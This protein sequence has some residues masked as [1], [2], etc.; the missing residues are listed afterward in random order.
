MSSFQTEVVLK[1]HKLS[2][3]AVTPVRATEGA[4]GL[5][6]YAAYETDLPPMS[7]TMVATDLAIELPPNCYGRVA[8]TSGLTVKK[9][10]DVGAGVVDCD[11]RGN[12]SVVLFNFGKETVRLSAGTK[13]AQLICEKIYTP[14]LRIVSSPRQLSETVRG[15]GGF[16]STDSTG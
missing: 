13:I 6:L 15:C 5:D 2:E 11:Y 14:E 10:I 16:G 7:R 4:A 3:F 9:F 12:I 8:P 1:V